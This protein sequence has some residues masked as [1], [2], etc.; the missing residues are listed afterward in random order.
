MTLLRLLIPLLSF[1]P[2]RSLSRRAPPCCVLEGA[3]YLWPESHPH[4]REPTCFLCSQ[5]LI[6]T[7]RRIPP[8]PAGS[9]M[10]APLPGAGLR[11]SPILFLPSRPPPSYPA[12][13]AILFLLNLAVCAPRPYSCA[14]ASSTSRLERRLHSAT[15]SEPQ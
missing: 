8:P 14:S 11:S 15:S 2:D 7:L 10:R 13:F 3:T 12:R 6:S 1:W 4:H 5:A 9:S